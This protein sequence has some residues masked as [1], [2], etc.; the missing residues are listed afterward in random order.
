MANPS[1]VVGPLVRLHLYYWGLVLT[2]ALSI[3]LAFALLL[4]RATRSL[5]GLTRAAEEIGAGNLD[6]WLP[7]PGKGE[8]GQLTLA[9]SRMARQI[10]ETIQQ[11][12]E[13]GRLAVV[14]QLSAYL[15]HEIRN[16][17]SSIKMNLQRMHRWARKGRIPPFTQEPVEISLAEVERLGAAVAGV[18]QLSRTHDAPQQMLSLHQVVAEASALLSEKFERQGV[19]LDLALDASADRVLGRLGQ[20][21]SMILNLMINALEAQPQGGYLGVQS[22]LLRSTEDGR[23]LIALRFRDR[24]SGVPPELSSQIFEPFFTTKDGGSGIGLAVAMQA[25]TENGGR[26]YLEEPREDPAGAEFVVAFPLAS[27]TESNPPGGQDARPGPKD[28]LNPPGLP[29]RTAPWE[30]P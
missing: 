17:L 3:I 18:L 12:E 11:V 22:E 30:V 15:A 19:V 7:P 1:G 9:L 13:S 23:P 25:V 14:G 8:L 2:I 21:K 28:D 16:P 29:P 20:I 26:L 6:P 5:R 10:R 24:G 4:A 27:M